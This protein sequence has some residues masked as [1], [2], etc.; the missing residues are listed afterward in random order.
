MKKI[1]ALAL[2]LFLSQSVFALDHQAVTAK[3]IGPLN[4]NDYKTTFRIYR[5]LA[6]QGNPIAQNNLGEMY[7]NGEGVK[8]D[9]QQAKAW[10]GKSCDNGNK[11]A[12]DEYRKLNEKSY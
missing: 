5:D 8:Q 2:S 7:A 1:I 4:D 3:V 10:F 6:E 11:S 12:C 9:H